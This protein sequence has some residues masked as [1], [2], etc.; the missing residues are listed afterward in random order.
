MWSF[1]QMKLSG[2]LV[3]PNSF[4]NLLVTYEPEISNTVIKNIRFMLTLE[5]FSIEN[6]KPYLTCKLKY[7]DIQV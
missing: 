4:T 2:R 6:G 3:G 5:S 1:V 7:F